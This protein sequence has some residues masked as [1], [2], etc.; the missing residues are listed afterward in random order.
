MNVIASEQLIPVDIDGTL[1]FWS[2]IKRGQRAISFTCPYTNAQFTVGVNEPN[3]AIVRER[4]ARGATILAWSASGYQKV[5]AVL[6]ALQLDHP[7]LYATSK[8]CN[9]LDDIEVQEW[10]GKRIFLEP[11]CGYGKS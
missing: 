3:L 10:M 11:D 7:N 6:K 9:Y 8:P 2:K 5:V 1:I 4:L